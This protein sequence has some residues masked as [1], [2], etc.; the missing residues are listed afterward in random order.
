MSVVKEET[1]NGAPCYHIQTTARSNDFISRFYEVRDEVN[2]YIDKQGIFSRRIEQLLSEGNYKSNRYTD[3][4]PE[5]LIAL[6]TEKK[7][8]LTEI[9]LFIQDVLSSLYLVR[10]YDLE[11]GKDI[12]ITTYAD[13]KVYP[14]R[15]KVDKIETVEVPAGR[16]RCFVIEPLL[17]S[18]GIFRQKGRLR[19]WM[20]ADEYKIPVKMTSKIII[21][22]IGTNLMTYTLGNTQ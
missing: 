13:G 5:R 1:V 6:N 17:Q 2:S 19:V 8:G 11:V 10:T 4:Y 15:I 20:T 7:Y 16:F 12:Y 21:G 14:L 22:S 18:D 3:F 9:P